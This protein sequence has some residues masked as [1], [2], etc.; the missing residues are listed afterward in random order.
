MTLYGFQP[1][2]INSLDLTNKHQMEALQLES[3]LARNISYD[4][5]M[6]YVE[7][8]LCGRPVVWEPGKT[9]ELLQAGGVDFR[10]VDE[11]CLILSEG[12]LA[13]QPNEK[14]GF[15]LAVVRIAGVTPNEAMYM[16]KPA[17]NA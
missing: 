13:C 4:P 11:H 5:E 6:L 7:C 10:T 17:G 1:P 12:C 3:R 14:H 8:H 15:S 9:T 16:D 2:F